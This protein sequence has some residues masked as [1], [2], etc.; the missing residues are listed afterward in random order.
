MNAREKQVGQIAGNLI[1]DTLDPE[2]RVVGDVQ[3][4][5]LNVGPLVRGATVET[6]ITGRGRLDL[7]LPS[8]DRPFRGTY[9]V[10]AQRA[11]VVGYELRNVAAR[12]RINW[13][14]I[15]VDGSGSG[16][17][18][19]VT[20]KGTIEAKSPLRLDL[21]GRAVHVD[22]RN[23]PPQLNAPSVPSNLQFSYTVA[24]R[25]PVFSGDLTM[26]ESTLADATI[27]AGTIGSFRVGGGAP[28]Y[29]AKGHVS[30]LDLQK[31]GHGFNIPALDAA[32]YQSKLNADFDVK[33]SGGG[34]DPLTIDANGTLVDSE[35]FR[36]QTPRF[37]FTTNLADGD[38]HVV[39]N[40]EFTGSIR[41]PF[42]AI[43]ASPGA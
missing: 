26:D 43:R 29:A 42:P 8:N 41:P 2:R 25:G 32:K 7:V 5:H 11:A 28:E 1:V 30:N 27:T 17:G 33:G 24:G 31:I 3:T 10:N 4:Q 20:A 39:A 6:D 38:A 36:A 12:G 13:P 9:A 15:T 18:G 21:A 34:Q 35:I 37:E 40:G 23:L 16:Y 14:T 19:R 22:L